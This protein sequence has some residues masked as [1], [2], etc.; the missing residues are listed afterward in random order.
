MKASIASALHI[1]THSLYTSCNNLRLFNCYTQQPGFM[2]LAKKYRMCLRKTYG[3]MPISVSTA[4]ITWYS[5][6]AKRATLKLI[7]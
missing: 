3:T 5:V 7:Y 6:S 2:D 4:T 1:N